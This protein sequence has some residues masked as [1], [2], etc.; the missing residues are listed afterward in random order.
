M[1]IR[2]CISTGGDAPALAGILREGIDDLLPS[3]LDRWAEC[4][5]DQRRAWKA[6]GVPME[7]RRPQLV[8]ALKRLY[9]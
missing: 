3:D 8:E 1:C 2:D 4:A 5:R 6:D 9:P 7:A